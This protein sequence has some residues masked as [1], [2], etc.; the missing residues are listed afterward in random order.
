M[1]YAECRMPN[2]VD[3]QDVGRRYMPVVQGTYALL[4]FKAKAPPTA[5]LS[6]FS[7]GNRARASAPG[8][9][10]PSA[11]C[12][13]CGLWPRTT[14]QMPCA[15]H[16]T[17]NRPQISKARLLRES[18]KRHWAAWSRIGTRM[19]QV[20]LRTAHPPPALLRLCRGRLQEAQPHPHPHPPS[21][22]L[23]AK[24]PFLWNAFSLVPK[25]TRY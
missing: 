22:L 3:S 21:N 12:L 25:R 2:A 16:R 11:V 10:A 23:S 1:P 19:W 14:R 18:R 5:L 17:S 20:F 8:G 4:A 9:V 6:C 24:L 15:G 7:F 13:R